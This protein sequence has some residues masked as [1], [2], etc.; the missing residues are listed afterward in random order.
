MGNIS[1]SKNHA[2]NEVGRLAPDIF[3]FQ[4][5]LYEVIA[6]DQHLSFYIFW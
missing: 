6:N 4:K 2:E 5:T 1:F 3:I